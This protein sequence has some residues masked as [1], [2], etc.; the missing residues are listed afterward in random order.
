MIVIVAVLVVIVVNV[1]MAVSADA[2]ADVIR[3]RFLCCA[4]IDVVREDYR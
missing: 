2:V 3:P 4:A 1:A